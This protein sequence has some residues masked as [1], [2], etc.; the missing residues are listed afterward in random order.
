MDEIS[1][2]FVNTK[3][4]QK[5]PA[6]YVR[7]LLKELDVH[8]IEFELRCKDQWLMPDLSIMTDTEYEFWRKA[9]AD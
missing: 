8:E 7:M 6:E 4:H 2:V 5:E 3:H 9:S 1:P